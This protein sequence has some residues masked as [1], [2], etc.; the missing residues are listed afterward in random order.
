MSGDA[1]QKHPTKESKNQNSFP[2]VGMKKKMFE[3]T[4]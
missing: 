2:Q 3:T 4:T 1:N